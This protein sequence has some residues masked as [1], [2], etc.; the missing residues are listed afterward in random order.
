MQTHLRDLKG[1][2]TD[3]WRL[4]LATLS[5]ARLKLKLVPAAGGGNPCPS[6]PPSPPSSSSF[7]LP[8]WLATLPGLVLVW[9]P[10]VTASTSESSPSSSRPILPVEMLRHTSESGA[11][12]CHRANPNAMSPPTA[13]VSWPLHEPR[14]T[15]PQVTLPPTRLTAFCSGTAGGG[16]RGS[17]SSSSSSISTTSTSSS[18]SSSVSR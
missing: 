2:L 3:R 15:Q 17:S 4:L 11:R 14:E 13:Q 10:T 16:G 8:N 12:P 6:S 7:S 1:S 5:P 9:A 18:S